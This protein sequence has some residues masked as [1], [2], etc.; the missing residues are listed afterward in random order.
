MKRKIA[1]AVLVLFGW[2]VFASKAQAATTDN[3]TVTVTIGGALDINLVEAT[4]DF[5]SQGINIT[6]V[7]ATG[8]TAQNS[9]TALTEDWQINASTFTANWNLTTAAPGPDTVRLS[10]QL[11]AVR[12]AVGG[13]TWSVFDILTSYQNLTSS[14]FTD[15]TSNGNDVPAAGSR[16]LWFKLET[17]TTTSSSNVQT[18]TVTVQAVVAS[19]F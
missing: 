17:P 14:A 9:S 6:T 1:T 3:M 16:T 5:G 18:L 19:T 4:Y 12:P 2:A 11:A 7:S 8:V 15:G 10:A 13:G